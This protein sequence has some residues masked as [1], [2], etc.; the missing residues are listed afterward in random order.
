MYTNR[1]PILVF[2]GYPVLPWIP[3]R[4]SSDMEPELSQPEI[5]ECDHI[6]FLAGI[7]VTEDAANPAVA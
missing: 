7:P 1:N 6:S 5:D 2:F 3:P 4:A